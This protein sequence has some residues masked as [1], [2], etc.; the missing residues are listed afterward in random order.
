[1][2]LKFDGMNLEELMDENDKQDNGRQLIAEANKTLARLQIARLRTFSGGCLPG[3][4]GLWSERRAEDPPS[5][6]T[7]DSVT[8][9]LLSGAFDENDFVDTAKAE[10]LDRL[11]DSFAQQLRLY[12]KRL[13]KAFDVFLCHNSEDKREVKSIAAQLKRRGLLPW[14]DEEEIRPGDNTWH[15]KIQQDIELIGSCA[16]IVGRAGIGPWQRREIE[17]VLQLFVERKHAIIPVILPS[18]QSVPELPIFLRSFE[19]V[20]YRTL[21]PDRLE[22]LIWGISGRRPA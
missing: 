1:M 20:D 15:S 3:Y 7:V 21:D 22:Q 13:Q 6:F 8:V 5:A 14:L 12:R 17:A 19:W 18:C 4:D 11:A 10:E 2:L 16:V 9:R